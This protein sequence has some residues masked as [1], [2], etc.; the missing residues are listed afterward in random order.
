MYENHRDNFGR[1]RFE[2]ERGNRD[3]RWREGED[4][5]RGE[6]M[7]QNRYDEDRYGD[8]PRGFNED[9]AGDSWFDA[10]PGTH[11]HRQEWD[12]NRG[13]EGS[14]RGR[15]QAPQRSSQDYA[16]RTEHGRPGDSSYFTG[17][18]GSWAVP[19]TYRP[20]SY[21]ASGFGAG[22]FAGGGYGE[23]YR[24]HGYGRGGGD[25]RG[26][27]DKAGDEIASWFG[28]EDAARRRE[29]DH[30][31]RGPKN[32]V[33]SDERIRDDANDRL[34]EDRR[35]DAGD[36]TVSVENGEVTINGTVPD[37]ASKRRAED[38]IE[39]ISGVK[40]V[41]NNLSVAA[42]SIGEQNRASSDAGGMISSPG[43]QPGTT[44]PSTSGA[45]TTTSGTVGYGSQDTNSQ[46]GTTKRSEQV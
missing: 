42:T 38:L 18:Q 20:S 32:Y 3:Q 27:L 15:G 21:G 22:G 46:D 36:V 9:Y 24:E 13:T 39:D 6:S 34:T 12:H 17:T 35:I 28:D 23:D 41:Q 11:G 25:H 31:G 30:R 44:S 33:R 40:H 29:Q 16:G 4:R 37:R 5:Y 2:S 1:R 19:P 45:S 8:R 14:Y 10:E 7:G 26:F 43:S